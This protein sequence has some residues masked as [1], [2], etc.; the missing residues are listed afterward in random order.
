MRLLRVC[1][2]VQLVW[3][4]FESGDPMNVLALADDATGALETGARFHSAG[5][6]ARVRFSAEL[7]GAGQ[8]MVIDTET[9]HLAAAEA[10]D[11][12]RGISRRAREA[13]ADS[14]YKKTDSTLRGPLAAEFTALLEVWPERPLVY[15]PAYPALGRT[16]RNG[17]LLVDGEPLARTAFAAD[18]LNPS[19]E[20][21]IP[22]RLASC[23]AE[24]VLVR[25]AAELPPALSPGRILVCDGET[26]ADLS[27]I[28]ALIAGANCLVA[29]TAA[30]ASAWA[31]SLS[32]T[33]PRGAALR[34][35][36][37][38]CLVVCGS[39][40]PASNRQVA[41]SAIPVVMHLPAADPSD[42][43]TRLAHLIEEHRWAAL[44]AAAPLAPEPLELAAHAGRTAAIA[45]GLGAPDCL[46]IFGGDTVFAILRELNIDEAE[47][48]GEI[49]PGVAVSTIC[50]NGAAMLL[51]T[52]AGG[53]GGPDY[54]VRIREILEKT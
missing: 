13:S 34:H 35:P 3:G 43:G 2:T 23:G 27:E 4:R 6:P 52:K 10:R 22:A 20:S 19:N 39:L 53:F 29:G 38:R 15:V 49:L 8:V 31:A 47:P 5:L 46:T 45:I 42:L 7:Q 18:P 48:A 32:K 41:E 25:S 33:E 26:D 21:S 11:R 24:I 1:S 14:I 50:H 28:A 40:H 17:L 51:V 36:V 37:R 12:I 44:C 54:L 9:R 30:M 16:V